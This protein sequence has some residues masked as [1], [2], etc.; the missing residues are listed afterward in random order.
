MRRVMM[1]GLLILISSCT[2]QEEPID[3]KTKAKELAH[4]YIMVDGHVD[5]PYKII[6]EWRDISVLDTSKNEPMN[7][8]YVKAT[9]GGLDA[10]F[11]SIYVAASYQDKGEGSNS[12][13]HTGGAYQRALDLIKITDRIAAEHP[14]KFGKV[15]HPDQIRENFKKGIKSYMYGMENGAPIEGDL[16]KLRDLAAKGIRYITLTHSKWNHLGDAS[17]DDTKHWNGL[18]PFGREVVAEMNKLGVIVDVSH[19]SDSTFYQAVA[20]SEAPVIAS[21]SSC[22]HFTPGFERNANDDMIKKLAAK[23]GVIMINFGSSFL[24][25]TANKTRGGAISDSIKA[26]L[27]AKGMDPEDKM[28]QAE[29]YEQ[30]YPFA[31]VQQV[32]DHI[33][34]VK[35]LVGVDHVGFGSD[36]DG[37]GNS[38]PTG[39]KDV[40]QYPNLIE[41]LLKRG[42]SDEEIEKVMGKNLLR[43]WDKVAEIAEK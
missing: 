43:V 12:D 38:L 17:Y 10:P 14:D 23:G 37:V 41:E 18:S 1:I 5:V 8:D 11:F 34:H 40:S 32:A 24:T 25:E 42:Y 3:L 26:I 22:R 29:L 27:K 36:F 21:H 30:I 20:A 13:N 2:K 35:N 7:Y 6:D 33:D 39:L 9:E 4:K 31:T 28:A 19:V 15:T 16:E